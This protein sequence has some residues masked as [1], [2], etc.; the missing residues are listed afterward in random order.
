MLRY[1]SLCLAALAAAVIVSLPLGGS[2][3]A[4]SIEEPAFAVVARMD[5][6]EIRR[7][8]P[9]IQAV[10][11][12][13][14]SGQTSSGFQRLAGYIFGGNATAESIAM[15]AP[16]QE[17]LGTDTPEMAFTMPAAY[18]MEDLPLPDSELV[19][20][21]EMPARYAAV[22]SFGGWATGGKVSRMKTEL[23]DALAQNGIETI[24][25]SAL[26]QY[27]PPWTLPFLRR[28]EITIDVEWAEDGAL[29]FAP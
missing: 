24:G 21:R 29:A 3:M 18:A 4:G 7:Y 13:R 14:S 5:G 25:P 27:N 8:E 10:T 1:P 16:V 6:V 26:N 23:L 2:A 9:S 12:L 20:L 15:T 22:V 19:A 17:T 11:Q 28:N